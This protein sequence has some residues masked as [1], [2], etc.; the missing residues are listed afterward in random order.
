MEKDAET[1]SKELAHVIEMA[2]G[3]P[4]WSGSDNDQKALMAVL[5]RLDQLEAEA[6]RLIERIHRMEGTR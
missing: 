5:A 3:D 4:R 2:A 6:V 1:Y